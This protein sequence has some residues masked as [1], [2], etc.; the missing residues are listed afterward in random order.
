L[1]AV[2]L[3]LALCV[4][5]IVHRPADN[6]SVLHSIVYFT[7]LYFLGINVAVGWEYFKH[8]IHRFYPL[9]GLVAI[10]LAGVQAS[11]SNVLGNSHKLKMFALTHFD[12]MIW[13]KAF[14][15]LFM[16]GLCMSFQHIKCRAV[17]LR[18][19]S[20]RAVSLIGATS[21]SVYFLHVWVLEW[22]NHINIIDSLRPNNGLFAWIYVI[23]IAVGISVG[24]AVATKRLL[25]ARSRYL[26]GY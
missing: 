10:G 14:L 1:R 15:S 7:P 17:S 16:L 9:F 8:A 24:I 20:L 5:S 4:A 2:V 26:I 13:Q 21:F 18:A 3:L 12:Y 25:G 11:Y 23:V 22:T 19:V 6:L